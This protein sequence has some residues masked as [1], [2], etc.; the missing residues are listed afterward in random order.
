[1]YLSSYPP[2][3][4]G[5][6][7]FCKDLTG[8]ISKKYPAFKTKILAINDNGSSMYN[9]NKNV[10]MQIDQDDIESYIEAAEKI[11]KDPNIDIVHI[12]HEFGLFGGEDGD[13]LILFLEK[14]EKPVVVTIHSIVPDPDEKRLMILR[15][16]CKRSSLVIVM[17][18]TA[19]KIL[20]KDYKIDVEN[21]RVIPHGIPDIEYLED[22]SKIKKKLKLSNRTVLSTFGLINEGKG[23]DYVI[24]ALPDLIKK[25]PDLLYLVIGETHPAVRKK[26]GE[27]YR[28]RL[29]DL[30]KNLG[31]VK[32]VKFYNRFVS[33][34]ELIN[35]LKASDIYVYSALDE[36]QIVSGTLAYAMGA[37]KALVATKSLYGK[38]IIDKNKRGHL[39]RIRSYRDIEEGIDRFMSDRVAMDKTRK[40]AYDYSRPMLWSNVADEH[41]KIFK[42]LLDIEG[43]L[44]VSIPKVK[45]SHLID[46]TD[47]TGVIQHAKH[48]MPN[49]F[50]GYCVDDNARALIA[51]S[52]CAHKK[53]SDKYNGLMKTYLSFLH[54][55][56][57]KDGFFHNFMAY[58][59]RFLDDKGSE[60]S[61]GRALWSV[62]FI[63]DKDI[64]EDIK[65]SAKYIFD[66]SVNNVGSLK[67]IRAIAFS[68]IGMYHY[69]NVYPNQDIKDKVIKLADSLVEEF[70]GNSD[71]EWKWFEKKVTYSNGKLPEALFLAYEMTKD[72]KYLEV[73]QATLKFLT[74]L[75]IIDDKL[76]LVGQN[77]WYCKEG[78]RS[79]FDQQPVDASS[80]VTAYVTAHRITKEKE[81]YDNALLSYSW[82]LGKNSINQ[83]MYDEKSGGCYDGLRPD[84]INLN[85]GSES[86]VCHL[87]ARLTL[88]KLENAG[89]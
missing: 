50:T 20:K 34:K 54:Y 40:K 5:I 29:L 85:Q 47:D 83:V 22:N 7:T 73:G 2:R 33:L 26:Y 14:L 72:K 86:T 23:I 43:N 3:E 44:D 27:A 42:E 6:A 80:M 63:L 65:G 30:V 24:K 64:N 60:D 1:M 46:L 32:H 74:S 21:V 10:T 38:E 9:Y 56:Q 4:C 35:Y 66:R 68:I 53:N 78:K 48:G 39:V 81:Y 16:V 79:Y 28:M 71:E 59:K 52:S 25:Y 49:R 70:N 45:L 51:I 37:G 8:A 89:L 82:F 31:L 17:A 18:E 11:N 62:G 76:V 61:F 41:M 84:S 77:G 58:D 15:A 13:Y 87:I 12:Q 88:N 19:V 36:N 67:S 55:A 69:H 57:H 75:L